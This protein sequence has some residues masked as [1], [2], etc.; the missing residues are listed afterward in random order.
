[1]HILIIPS[2]RYLPTDEP[3][4]GIFQSDQAFALQRAGARIGILS[5]ELQSLYLLKMLIQEWVAGQSVSVEDGIKV[6]RHFGWFLTQF[7]PRSNMKKYLY[8]GIRLYDR[9]LSEQGAPNLIH[10]HNALRAGILAAEINKRYGVPYIITEHSSDYSK[11]AIRK[12]DFNWIRQAYLDADR[13]LVVSRNLGTILENY[14]GDQIGS[15]QVIPNMLDSIFE[16]IDTLTEHN[17]HKNF[18]FLNVGRLVE[19]K[20]QDLLITAFS[21]NFRMRKNICLRIVGDGPRLRDL[22]KIANEAGVSEQVTFTGEVGRAEVLT[23]MQNCDVYVHCSSSE[24][25]GVSIIEAMACGKPVVSTACG[26]PDDLVTPDSGKLVPV[27]DIESLATSMESVLTH[28]DSYKGT[29]IRKLCLERFSGHVVSEA[30]MA[31]YRD[32]L[33]KKKRG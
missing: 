26:G 12:S 23:E 3:L 1:M 15:W 21:R 32:V 13:C 22:K 33:Q 9:Y 24:T 29:R 18:T 7:L 27:G 14:F 31:I 2:E 30:L 16:K 6:Y 4:S 28:L 11:R 10:A 25:F 19:V 17:G 20:R 8:A 5:V